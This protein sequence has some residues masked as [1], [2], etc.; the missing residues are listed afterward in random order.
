M[1]LARFLIR[2]GK[3]RKRSRRGFGFPHGFHRC[4]LGRLGLADFITGFVA[5]HHHSQ[6]SDHAKDRG[7][8]ERA[9]RKAGVPTLEQIPSRNAHHENRA[10]AVA[11]RQH[12]HKFG[13]RGRAHHYR[14]EVDQFH[15][16]GFMVEGRAQRILHPGVGDQDQQSRKVGAK[17]GQE[18][19]QQMALFR[20]SIPAEEEQADK[21]RFQEE[22]QQ[23]FDRQRRAENVAGIVRVIR[24]VRAELELHGD[25]G[26]HA[27]REIDAKELA[28]ELGHVAIDLVAGA[29]INGFHDDQ[30]PG[31]PER[32]GYKQEVVQRHDCELQP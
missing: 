28:P 26:G 4:E 3:K 7:D 5:H 23:A 6:R 19:R 12:M 24:P 14:P 32:Q 31:K 16:H 20:Q 22:G 17:R 9:Q 27:K 1:V 30:H 13:L 2:Q 25:A 10:G 18:S 8:T 29:H 21:G 15:A 11:R